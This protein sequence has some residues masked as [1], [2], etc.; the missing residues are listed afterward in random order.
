M[1][2]L[3]FIS[4]GFYFEATKNA[5]GE[6]IWLSAG[7]AQIHTEEHLVFTLLVWFLSCFASIFVHYNHLKIAFYGYNFPFGNN[8]DHL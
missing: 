2:I 5:T 1:C 7:V 4:I 3:T 6:A 8:C